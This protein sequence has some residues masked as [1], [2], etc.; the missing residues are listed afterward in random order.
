M[1]ELMGGAAT[2]IKLGLHPAQILGL[3]TVQ[4]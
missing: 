1:R 2:R 3:F 4:T